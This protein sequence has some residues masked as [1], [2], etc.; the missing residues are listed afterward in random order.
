M[1]QA[2]QP[3]LSRSRKDYLAREASMDLCTCGC[4][5][6]SLLKIR[7]SLAGLAAEKGE[8]DVEDD[9][10]DDE[11]EDDEEDDEDDDEEDDQE[12]DEEDDEEDGE[13]KTGQKGQKGTQ[14]VKEDI[15]SEEDKKEDNLVE[16]E[17]MVEGEKQEAKEEG[18][19]KEEAVQKVKRKSQTL[20]NEPESKMMKKEK[21]SQPSTLPMMNS[22]VKLADPEDVEKVSERRSGEQEEA[23]KMERQDETAEKPA[24]ER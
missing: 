1:V 19:R 2:V 22:E 5:S 20:H 9:E 13:D 14:K 21:E 3:R 15:K 16:P 4:Y 12:D 11:E 7:M 10:D 18:K 8:D 24:E 6:P 17:A 23:L